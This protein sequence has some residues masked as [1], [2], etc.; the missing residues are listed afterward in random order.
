MRVSASTFNDTGF[1][2]IVCRRKSKFMFFAILV[3]EGRKP[4]LYVDCGEGRESA[5]MFNAG[6]C[7]FAGR[8]KSNCYTFF[9][10]VR[11]EIED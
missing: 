4:R 3:S 5:S 7:V 8:K 2:V 9:S 11:D 1:N 6:F 10:S